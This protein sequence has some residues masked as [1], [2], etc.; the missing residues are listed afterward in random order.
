MKKLIQMFHKGFLLVGLSLMC[1]PAISATFA[2]SKSGLNIAVQQ[3]KEINL[4]GHV[5]D[6][7]GN[8]VIGATVHIEGSSIGG[9]TDVSGNYDIKVPQGSKIIFSY[10][11]Y[12]TVSRVVLLR[13]R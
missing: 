11:G 12:K 6:Q 7:A 9:I 4:K 13:V 3:P 1:L 2:R 10:I 5:T 8:P